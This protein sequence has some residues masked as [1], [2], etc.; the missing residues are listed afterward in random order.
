MA[1]Y[2]DGSLLRLCCCY[3]HDSRLVYIFWHYDFERIA[4]EIALAIAGDV[5]AVAGGCVDGHVGSSFVTQAD[6]YAAVWWRVSARLRYF[7]R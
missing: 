5:R 7:K 4:T 1:S 2:I 6:A 3:C